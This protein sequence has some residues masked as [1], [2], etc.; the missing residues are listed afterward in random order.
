[1]IDVTYGYDETDP[2]VDDSEAV[3]DSWNFLDILFKM[4]LLQCIVTLAYCYN[5]DLVV[6]LI[7]CEY[8]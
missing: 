7:K 8:S 6:C 4:G 2:F 5:S 3:S 1:M